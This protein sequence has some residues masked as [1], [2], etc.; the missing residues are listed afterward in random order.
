MIEAANHVFC[1]RVRFLFEGQ[2]DDILELFGM[3]AILKSVANDDFGKNFIIAVIE[4]EALPDEQWHFGRQI[5]CSGVNINPVSR[6]TIFSSPDQRYEVRHLVESID[7]HLMLIH[8]ATGETSH[9]GSFSLAGF[10]ER[11]LDKT[12]EL[13]SVSPRFA[14][15]SFP[16]I[17]TLLDVSV[18]NALSGLAQDRFRFLFRRVCPKNEDSKTFGEARELVTEVVECFE[19]ALTDTRM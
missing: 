19:T 15:L 12:G 17:S 3:I 10:C 2:V 11:R 5:L 1:G 9:E 4:A 7:I 6:L 8:G 13:T 18:G 14:T 16:E